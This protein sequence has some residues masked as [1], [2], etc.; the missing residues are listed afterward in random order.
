MTE[1]VAQLQS[2]EDG[3]GGAAEHGEIF[4]PVYQMLLALHTAGHSEQVKERL[5]SV[6]DKLQQASAGLAGVALQPLL[7]ATLRSTKELYAG[8][9]S[10]T[11][12]EVSLQG[13]ELL[14]S[15]CWT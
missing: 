11:K 3:R 5:P 15:K 10:D 7:A 8:S 14:T 2:D 12:L 13:S 1:T 4:Q 9:N 6:L